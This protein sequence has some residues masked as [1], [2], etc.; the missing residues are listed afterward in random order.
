MSTLAQRFQSKFDSRTRSRGRQYFQEELVD[1]ENLSG[2][3]IDS[4]VWNEDGE[5]YDVSVVLNENGTWRDAACSCPSFSGGYLCKHIWAT[6]LEADEV[7]D[8]FEAPAVS[9]AEQSLQNLLHEVPVDPRQLSD[10]TRWKIERGRFDDDVFSELL[11]QMSSV[12]AGLLDAA[13]QSN[14]KS[15]S[16]PAAPWRRWMDHVS[17]QAADHHGGTQRQLLHEPLKDIWLVLDLAES[18]ARDR[19]VILFRQREL[20]STGVPGKVKALSLDSLQ[21]RTISDPALRDQFGGLLN[22]RDPSE[23]PAYGYQHGYSN[24][25]DRSLPPDSAL[26]LLFPALCATGRLVASLNTDDS[27]ADAAPLV[28]DDGGRWNFEVL[29][30]EDAENSQWT[31]AGR[32]VR[33]D[34]SIAASEVQAVFKGG[35]LV[36]N[37]R[38][39]SFEV[40]DSFPWLK[41]LQKTS[42]F[43]VPFADRDEFLAH[44]I[45]SGGVPLEE[46]P[47]MLRPAEVLSEPA[48]QFIV[49]K[50]GD[51][52]RWS[53]S[54]GQ[55]Y[56][57]VLFDYGGMRIAPEARSRGVLLENGQC[58]YRNAEAE[59][60]LLGTLSGLPLF[61][62]Q[63]AGERRDGATYEFPKKQLPLLVRALIE[64]GWT[65]NAQ[66]RDVKRSAGSFS[67]SV[68]SGIDWFD[69]TA[70]VDFG[71]AT[72]A[73]PELL[74]AARAGDEYV[75]LDDGSF[76]LLPEDWLKKYGGLLEMGQE[77]EDGV[78]FVPSQA[79]ILDALL[80]A[81][82]ETKLDKAFRDC[83]RRLKKFDGVKPKNAPRSFQGDLRE[84]QQQG[85]GWLNFLREF[86]LGGCLADDMG[87]GKTI[88]VLSLLEARRT[89]RL[90]KDEQRRPS[91]VVVPKSLV[92]NW[93][94]EAA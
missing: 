77:T 16:A 74:K 20:R 73:L 25:T 76:G 51:V 91:L 82:S 83:C 80:A 12:P 28:W 43:S 35:V 47:E 90:K 85:L 41:T 56:A 58:L 54:S 78:R 13:A 93:V 40:D 46:L 1:L 37:G 33:G 65:V 19:P 88:Q 3:R 17:R 29:I 79:L 32:F 52:D 55:L 75:Q 9:S 10:E 15:E 68:S 34:E 8:D 5:F 62:V 81:Q 6:L 86:R 92:F 7:G 49:L 72:V 66:G 53:R 60:R 64:R 48:P 22:W 31:V 45:D 11:G 14:Q 57:A 18:V 27:P 94:D 67:M 21:L 30:S 38:I 36:H 89:R 44:L 39:S 61:P 70:E 69:L 87:L 4:S 24:R 63:Y 26:R 23:R 71:D 84:Y 2:S 50:E 59:H 42:S